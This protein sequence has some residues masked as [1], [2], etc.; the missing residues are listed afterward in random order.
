MSV[1]KMNGSLKGSMLSRPTLSGKLSVPKG[2]SEDS[3]PYTGAYEVT[4][5][6]DETQVLN[7]AKKRLDKN[8]TIHPVPYVET[9]NS[10]NGT[11]IYIAERM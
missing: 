5:L 6:A 8:I 10:S 9:S 11:T 3:E 4:P 7:T 2:I 1:N